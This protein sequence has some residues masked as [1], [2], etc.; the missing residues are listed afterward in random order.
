MLSNEDI[1]NMILLDI[2]APEEGAPE[3]FPIEV[4]DEMHKR[5]KEC[6]DK[7]SRDWDYIFSAA[8][9]NS[10]RDRFL[11]LFKSLDHE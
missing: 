10:T 9:Q 11:E 7:G 3:Y 5:F 8:P 1:Q 6:T 4:R 2:I